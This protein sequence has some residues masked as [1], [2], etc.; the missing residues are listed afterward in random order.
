V[1][2]KCDKCK[3]VGSGWSTSGKCPNCGA[4]LLVRRSRGEIG[5][6]MY[7]GDFITYY[8]AAGELFSILHTF[9]HTKAQLYVSPDIDE[10]LK[11]K[12]FDY[13]NYKVDRK[14]CYLEMNVR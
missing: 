12:G 13:F 14:L 10:F 6:D 4:S 11:S 1:V 7:E 5:G 8:D 9:A 3:L 2:Y